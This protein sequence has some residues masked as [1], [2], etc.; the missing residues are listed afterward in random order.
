MSANK[1]LSR[2]VTPENVNY[3]R[4]NVKAVA[5][6][7]H[8]YTYGI[9]SDPL[10]QFAIMF[11]TLVHDVDHTGVSNQ[12]R[13]TEEPELAK[14]YK[15]KSVA[16]QNSIDLAWNLLMD[17]K[18]KNLQHALFATETEVR[19][20]RQLLVNLVMSTDIFEPTQ[21]STRNMRWDKVFH[22]DLRETVDDTT[23]RS[24]KA[25]IVTEHIIQA[26]DVCHSEYFVFH[27]RVPSYDFRHSTNIFVS[28]FTAMQHW[29]VY[30]KW[31]E[32]LFF[33]MY[34]AFQD[35]R[36]PKDPSEGWYNGELWFF[37]NYVIPLA[38]KLE[39]CGVFGVTS[40]ECLNY[41]LENRKEWEVKGQNIVKEMVEKLVDPRKNPSHLSKKPDEKPRRRG[42]FGYYARRSA[43]FTMAMPKGS[44]HGKS[45]N[46]AEKRGESTSGDNDDDSIEL[47]LNDISK[48]DK[49][50]KNDSKSPVN[51]DLG[52][53]TSSS[54]R[55]ASPAVE[56]SAPKTISIPA[57]IPDKNS[58]DMK[59][60]PV[61]NPTSEHE[62]DSDD[63]DS[64]VF[65]A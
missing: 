46:E 17:P 57:S 19:R 62:F 31:N 3:H 28:S 5:S 50:D 10:T 14:K 48:A 23:F 60:A 44:T 8:D 43:T 18:F 13:E 7:L 34:R 53:S 21:K 54:C 33:E 61:H 27:M 36:S 52:E 12:Q 59:A 26:A 42:S 20:F 16:E 45:G 4:T 32:R 11:S 58:V 55:R 63:D 40:D 65:N 47:V 35:G 30:T 22:S 15:N 29:Q 41:A 51:V 37:D 2:I 38:K 64:I 25:T 9:T 24:L 49:E 6:D 1:L 56:E 39:E